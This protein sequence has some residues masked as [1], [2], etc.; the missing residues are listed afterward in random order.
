[1]NELG[2]PTSAGEMLYR[3]KNIANHPD[4]RT[5][6]AV[7]NNEIVGMAGL[8]RGIFYEKNGGYLRIVAFVVKQTCRQQGI[9]KLLIKA[10]EDWAITQGLTTILL[11]SG[12]RDERQAAYMFYQKMGYM[13]KSSGFVKELA[14][15]D[16]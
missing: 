10:A 3:Y 12:K 15:P 7:K 13:V 8:A 2:Y 14:R 9:G 4:Y 5:I 11:N 16:K 1:M 6:V